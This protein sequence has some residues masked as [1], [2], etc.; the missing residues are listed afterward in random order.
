MKNIKHKKWKIV[1]GLV[2]GMLLI[3]IVGGGIYV[4]NY[5]H[6]DDTAIAALES[7]SEVTVETN[8]NMTVFSPDDPAAG[9]IF[10]P[11][12]KVEYTAYAPLMHSLAENNILCILV[13]M[14]FNLAVLDVD[15][16]EGIPEQFSE[17]ETWYIGGHSL[18]GSMAASCA[19]D[20]VETYDGLV[21]LASY[22][23]ADLSDTE[24][25]V[26][27]IYGSEDKVLNLDKFNE[28]QSNLPD[29]FEG[30]IIDGGCH[31][32]FGSYGP[33]DGD[34]TPTITVEEQTEKTT[35]LLVDFFF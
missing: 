3:V 35:E 17:I 24:M 32:Y 29:T 12:G 14:P 4:N 18:G 13:E 8:E 25:K 31:A 28:Y 7:D 30:Y 5:Y 34:G 1:S 15:A 16:A 10:Y 19:A 6:A 11:G 20:N 9:F 27:S 22:S 2:V 21:L 33:Q 23:T 26:I